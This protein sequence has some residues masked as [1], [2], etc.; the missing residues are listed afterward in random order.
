M[1]QILQNLRTGETELVDVPRP[2]CKAGHLLVATRRTVIS[3]GS[4]RMLVEFGQGNLL[5]K[6]RSQPDRVKDVLNK[7]QT[8]GVLTTVETVFNKLDQPLPLGYCNAGVVIEVGAGVEGFQIGDRVVSNGGHAEIVCVPKNLCAKI[9][10]SVSDEEAAF[11][12][13]SAISLQGIR[14]VNPTL[15]E[16]VAVVG[17]G[18]LGLLAVQMLVANG[19]HVLGIDFDEERLALARAFGATTVSLG[20]GEDPVAAANVFSGG[21]G[22][23]AV[24]ITASTPSHDPMHQAAEMSRKRGRIVLVGVVGLNLQRADFYEK[25]LSFQVSCSYGPGRYDENYE[26]NGN[27]YPL[28]FVRWTEQRNFEAVLGLMASGRIVIDSLVTERMAQTEAASA[29]KL[30]TDGKSALGIVLTYPEQP[31]EQPRTVTYMPANPATGSSPAGSATVGVIGAGNFAMAVLLPA[32]QKSGATLHTIASS[33]GTTASIA[34]KKFGFQQATTD[35]RSM[36][37]DPAIN[38]IVITTRHNTHAGMVIEALEAGKHVFVEKPLALNREELLAVRE[39]VQ[40]AP[41]QQLL[42]GLNRRFSPLTEKM[43]TLLTGRSEPI[44]VSYMVNAGAIPLNHWAQDQVVGGG[45][46]IGEGCHFVDVVRYLVGQPIVGV[47]ARMV[48]G[49]G[50]IPM[51]EDKMT[52]TLEF[53]DGSLGTVHYFANG[54]KR[55]PKERVEAFSDGRVLSLDNFTALRGFGW[56]GFRP[57][58]LLRQDKGHNSELQQFVNRISTGGDWLIPWNELEEVALAT[59]TATERALEPPKALSLATPSIEEINK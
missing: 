58:R 24:L 11:T 42:V 30:L 5:A 28:G 38:T 16:R 56:S 37:A 9:P 7:M 6:A 2:R 34:A 17:L 21:R 44:T 33:G 46:I 51:R 26:A 49:S 12:V 39:A 53:A 40:N 41:G 13:L 15:G 31:I 35:Y 55:F 1:K 29:Y 36:L 14:L 8:D 19:C 4:E 25:E 52:I 20:K 23:D 48:G 32:L 22:M 50:T 10:D 45:R 3:A 47:D 54:S 59:F 43:R 57:M 18:L 27:D